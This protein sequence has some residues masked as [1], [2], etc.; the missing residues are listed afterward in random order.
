[1][2]DFSPW[3]V[4]ET[5]IL[6]LLLLFSFC[7]LRGESF[8]NIATTKLALSSAFLITLYPPGNP[9]STN[10]PRR[11]TRVS[12]TCTHNS[13]LLDFS[14]AAFGTLLPERRIGNRRPGILTV[15]AV[16]QLSFFIRQCHLVKTFKNQ[17]HWEELN[18]EGPT[19][20]CRL[21]ARMSCL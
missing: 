10:V 20:S 17:K 16:I 14:P 19:H 12:Q 3:C 8:L 15:C 18:Y 6:H 7:Y 13:L 9:A 11:D 1:M 4:L 2:I 5:Q 21:I